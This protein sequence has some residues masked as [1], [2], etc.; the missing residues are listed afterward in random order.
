MQSGKSKTGDSMNYETL[1][2]RRK[3]I[4][5][6]CSI[7][8]ENMK[9]LVD[10]SN[11]V[12]DLAHNAKEVLDRLD[13]EFEQQTGLNDTDMA[14]LFLAVGLQ[15]TRIFLINKLTEIQKAGTGNTLEEFLHEFQI[16]MLGKFDNGIE[17]I[18][19][20]YY[21]PLNQIITTKGV[22]YDATA[23][24]S[25]KFPIFK[26]LNNSKGA[27]HRFSTL[28]HEPIV[29][30]LFGTANILTNTITCFTNPFIT[31]NHVFYTPEFKKPK[32]G[33]YCSSVE[34]V[35]KASNR[36]KDD[37]ES[38]AAAVI[39]QIIHI[40]TDMFTPCGIQLPLVNLVLSKPEIEEFTKQ[41]STGD[42]VKT[43]TSYTLATFVDFIITIIHG[44]LY[45]EKI[46]DTRDIYKIKTNKIIKYSNLIATSSNVIWVGINMYS[47]NESAIKNLDIGG[48]INT[49]RRLYADR[50]FVRQ[51]KEE[52]V[53]GGFNRLI[54]GNELDLAE[55]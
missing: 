37:K 14:F 44:L 1:H 23:F 20:L 53:F 33:P 48:L 39:K 36:I 29:G 46:C 42:L 13:R 18:A 52:F 12:A 17:G 31:T 22:P 19:N 35:M 34:M 4:E 41:F 21:A 24:D 7:V 15:C 25:E 49:V 55:V 47:G 9:L 11:R 32:I 40:G 43:G 10:E 26:G 8:I 28:G 45:D 27:N 50:E 16:D 2:N 54:Q 51:V 38:V 5:G 3:S 30:L 6:D